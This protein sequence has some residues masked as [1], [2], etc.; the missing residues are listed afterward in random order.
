MPWLG[1][2]AVYGALAVIAGAFGAHGLRERVAPDQLAAWNTAAEYQL[3]HSAVL[4]GLALYGSSSGKSVDLPA[5][6]FAGGVLLFSGSIYALVLTPVRWLGPI[7]P[8]GGLL[9][10]AAW[11]S[12]LWSARS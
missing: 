3:V 1:I 12:L 4:L 9:M 8:L 11:F 7:T 6:L 5:W 2:A 10:I